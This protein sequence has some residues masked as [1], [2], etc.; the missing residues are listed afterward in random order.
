MDLI[1]SLMKK[2]EFEINILIAWKTQD[3]S[4][5]PNSSPLQWELHKHFI[6]WSF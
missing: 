4:C 3:K 6:F 1:S 2:V 5:L